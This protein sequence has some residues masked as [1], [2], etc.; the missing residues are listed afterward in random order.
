M[1]EVLHSH[2]ASPETSWLLQY[3]GVVHY[4]IE[5]GNHEER[6]VDG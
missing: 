6:R 4:E 3:I 2:N 5:I 1:G